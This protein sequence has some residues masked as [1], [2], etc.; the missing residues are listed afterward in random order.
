MIQQRVILC[1]LFT[2]VQG[3]IIDPC[4]PGGH[5]LLY[6][7][8]DRGSNCTLDYYDRICD[9][10]IQEKWYRIQSHDDLQSRTMITEPPKFFECGTSSPIWMNGLH[11]TQEEGIVNRT[12]CVLG[13][14]DNC[15]SRYDIMVKNCSAYFVYFLKRTQRCDEGYCFSSSECAKPDPCNPK[16]YRMIEDDGG[17]SAYC[18]KSSSNLCDNQLRTYWYRVMKDSSDILMP[19]D[20]IDMLSCG[21][22]SPIWLNGT[23][24]EVNDKTVERYACVSSSPKGSCCERSYNI[25]MRNC[26]SFTVY[27]LTETSQTHCPERYCFGNSSDCPEVENIV[28][29]RTDN[30]P[31]A[32]SGGCARD[33]A[34]GV[35][36]G[37]CVSV[38]TFAAVKYFLSKYTRVGG[39]KETKTGEK[40]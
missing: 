36:A 18:R 38:V 12:A 35:T 6:R 31:S 9:N 14:S 27:Q 7:S 8:G 4:D 34:I 21:T 30:T 23:Y 16:N 29:Q 24:P 11:P 5:S 13:I 22:T 3:Q 17:R 32:C 37:V 26:S 39:P 25:K 20:C 15:S 40:I 2:S 1:V 33:V 19:T 10:S 28:T